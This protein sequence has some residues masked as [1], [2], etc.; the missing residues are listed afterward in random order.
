MKIFKG[1]FTVCMAVLLLSGCY[2]KNEPNDLVY[3]T[4]VGIDVRT[5]NNYNITLQYARV[6]EINSGSESGE[7]EA[8]ILDT[9]TVSAPS[10]YSAVS[11]ANHIISKQFVLSHVKLI[12]FSKEAAENGVADFAEVMMRSDELRPHTFMAVSADSAEDYLKSVKPSI[13]INPIKYYELVYNNQHSAYIPKFDNVSLCFYNDGVVRDV[14][15]P[16]ASRVG[17]GEDEKFAVGTQK[18]SDFDSDFEYKLKNYIAGELVRDSKNPSEVLGMAIFN[19]DKLV[20]FGGS[21][22]TELYNMLSGDFTLNYTAFRESATGK[23]VTVKLEQA[24]KPKLYVDTSAEYPLA[25]IRIYLEGEFLGL[26]SECINETD[27][28]GFETETAKTIKN[29]SEKFLN[30]MRDDYSSDVLGLGIAAKRNFLTYKAFED[31][32]WKSKYNNILF[33]VDV[34]FKLRRTGQIF[35]NKKGFE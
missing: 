16:V 1:I 32:D 33:D 27:L 19:R 24:Q 12:V 6:F 4:A 34:D 20:G 25:K 13:E 29:A 23:A 31:Y 17:N 21:I 18:N 8:N 9:V 15:M 28:T 3:A 10:I 11:L 7:S 30:R 5:D 2:D 14:V 22:E 35:R 26:P